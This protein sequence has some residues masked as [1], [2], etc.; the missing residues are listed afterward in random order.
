MGQTNPVIAL[1]IGKPM[2]LEHVQQW[3]A[4]AEALGFPASSLVEV[5]VSGTLQ[6]RAFTHVLGWPLPPGSE[7]DS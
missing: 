6:V 1:F 7:D 3:A 2:S 4:C 5:S